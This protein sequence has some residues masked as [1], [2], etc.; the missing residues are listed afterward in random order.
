[1]KNLLLLA[2]QC[3]LDALPCLEGVDG[4][5]CVLHLELVGNNLF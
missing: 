2:R 3:V 5:L 1:M 4:H